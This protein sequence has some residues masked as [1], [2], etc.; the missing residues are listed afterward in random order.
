M[1]ND[2]ASAYTG[3]SA[4]DRDRLQAEGTLSVG[5]GFAPAQRA[6]MPLYTQIRETLRNRILAGTYK[7]HECMPSENELVA[8]FGVSRVTVRQALNDLKSEGLI[9]KIHGKGTFVAKPKAVQNLMRLEGFGEAMSR[10]G[11]ETFSRVLGHQ[12]MRAG[13]AVGKRL[14]LRERDEVMEIRRVR[15]LDR[16]P[17]SLDVTYVPAAIGERLVR[18]DLPR[19]DIFVILENDYGIALGNAD[20]QIESMAADAELG[21]LLHIPEGTPILKIERLTYTADGRP[22]DFEYLH[23]RGDA[24]QYRMQLE[25]GAARA[26]LPG[27]TETNQ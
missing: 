22:L 7:S 5:G 14:Q 21:P 23:Y 2:M 10:R 18:E 11:H 8:A 17:V 4:L 1:E 25:R 24:F 3:R 26:A 6:S 16:E 19:R 27:N 20:L 9:F 13:K 12:L 15:Y